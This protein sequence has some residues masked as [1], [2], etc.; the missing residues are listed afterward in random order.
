MLVES[1]T[2]ALSKP[3]VT[4]S[5]FTLKQPVVAYEDYGPPDGPVILIAH[6]GLADH[7][8]AGK[9]AESDAAPGWW[10]DLIGPGKAFDTGRFRVLCANSLGS[11]FGT[12]CARSIDPDT[13]K[14]Y[15]PTF[16]EVTLID[17]V[18]FLKAFL[19]DLGVRRL[20]L[21]A[22]P[23]MGSLQSL[24]MAALYPGF[25]GGVVAVGTAGRMP[26]GGMT[27]HHVL[28]RFIRMDP[29]FQGG[30]YDP[31]EPLP[32]LE[33]IKLVSWL[34]FSHEQVIK[35]LCWDPIPEGPDAQDRRSQAVDTF[36]GIDA[37]MRA[38]DPNCYLTILTAVNSYD[39]GRDADSYEAGVRRIVCPVLLMNI[40]TDREF[41]MSWADELAGMLEAV[42][43]GQARVVPLRS[44]WGHLGCIKEAAQMDAPV[45]AF[46]QRL[47]G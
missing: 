18:R 15:G 27:M 8:A 29:G 36:L 38:R 30:W 44:A 47:A 39:L 42:R 1:K 26:P 34:Y 32:V 21:M 7:H 23:S 33:Q 45:R 2:H 37:D 22:G 41:D 19:D 20:H 43:P 35:Q 16:P 10:D 5:G 14:R 31:A 6:G 28:M 11:M 46:M 3:F 4:S 25:V 17:M 13:G 9:R 12:T 40:D 24:Q